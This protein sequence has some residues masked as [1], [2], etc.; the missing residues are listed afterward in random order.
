MYA[1]IQHFFQSIW[2]FFSRALI[3]HFWHLVSYCSSY[4]CTCEL[5]WIKFYDL[6]HYLMKHIWYS[7]FPDINASMFDQFVHILIIFYLCI[8]SVSHIMFM[9]FLHLAIWYVAHY[10]GLKL[11]LGYGYYSYISVFDVFLPLEVYW[12]W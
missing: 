10:D 7:S 9:F 5:W 1:A 8:Y 12:S 4:Y 11:S 3:N 6:W 2:H